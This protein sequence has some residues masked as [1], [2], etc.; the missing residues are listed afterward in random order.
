MLQYSCLENS[1]DRGDL[2]AVVHR[3]AESQIQLS[4]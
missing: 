4:D 3:A 2:Q 1:V